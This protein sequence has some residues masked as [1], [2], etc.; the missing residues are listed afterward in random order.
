[1]LIEDASRFARNL[2]LGIIALAERSPNRR[3]GLDH[4]MRQKRRSSATCP[5][6]APSELEK[7]K[8]PT[9]RDGA[10]HPQLVSRIVQRL[11]G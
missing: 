9:P 10:W 8:V 7:R 3:A 1:M 2:E 5:T 4:I 6:S 11:E